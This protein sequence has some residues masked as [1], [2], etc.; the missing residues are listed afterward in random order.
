MNSQEIYVMRLWH[1]QSDDEA[2]RVTITDTKSQQKLHFA[3]FETLLSF[4]REKLEQTGR[5]Q[6]LSETQEDKG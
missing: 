4:F 5:V 6:S 3:N 2:W 1:E